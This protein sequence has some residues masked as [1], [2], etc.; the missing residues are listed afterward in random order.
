MAGEQPHAFRFA[1]SEDAETVV[2]NF[3]NPVGTGRRLFGRA[4]EAR[5]ERGNAARPGRWG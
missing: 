2:L 1:P 3:V 5:L 4:R